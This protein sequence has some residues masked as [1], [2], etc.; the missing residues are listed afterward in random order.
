[1]SSAADHFAVLTCIGQGGQEV[2]HAVQSG[3][4]LVVG[5]DYRP[6][7]VCR[8]G[9]KEHRFLG[10]GIVFPFIEGLAVDGG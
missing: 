9:V 8:V 10:L 2:L 5:F 4:F 3:A 7:S 1:M 6:G